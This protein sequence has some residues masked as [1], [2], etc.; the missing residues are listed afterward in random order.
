[1]ELSAASGADPLYHVPHP[2]LLLGVE[3]H[4]PSPLY[5][6]GLLQ[7]YL[8]HRVPKPCGMVQGDRHDC[9]RLGC[10]DNVGGIVQPPHPNFKD[11]YIAALQGKPVQGYCSHQL[12]LGDNY[13]PGIKTLNGGPDFLNLPYELLF[14]YHL[15]IYLKALPKVQHIRGDINARPI[16]AL[17]QDA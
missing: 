1:M 11:S 14:S 17:P 9:R 16:A 2:R 5:D 6:A 12:E 7:G 13:I 8:L 4:A 15:P 3:H 10:G